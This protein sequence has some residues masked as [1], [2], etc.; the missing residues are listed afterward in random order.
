MIDP[1]NI[2]NY[3]RTTA[4]LEEFL[5][6]AIV[7]AGKNSQVQARKL[8]AFLKTVKA[9]AIEK[10]YVFE[11]GDHF[12]N[13]R[14]AN[15]NKVLEFA[16]KRVKMG[17]YDRILKTLQYIITTPVCPYYATFDDLI[18]IPGVGPKTANF[19]LLHSK[20]DYNEAVLDTH[21]LKWLREIGY[22]KAPKIT[23]QDPKHYKMWNIV[24]K[25]EAKRR[26][27]I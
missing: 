3:N 24:F 1:H 22:D 13:I 5:L 19:F 2:T 27:N 11:S 17:Q 9:F 21:I 20:E 12:A 6:F 26:F 23:P 10:G 14:V 8:S 7:V 15:N 4:E 16:L 18:K 25:N